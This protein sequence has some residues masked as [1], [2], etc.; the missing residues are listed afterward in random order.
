[1][2]TTK[3]SRQAYYLQT[4]FLVQRKF[5]NKQIIYSPVKLFAHLNIYAPKHQYTSNFFPKTNCS[6]S[7]P[8][9]LALIPGRD[10]K[11]ISGKFQL[12]VQIFSLKLA[13]LIGLIRYDSRRTLGG[14]GNGLA[15]TVSNTMN[16]SHKW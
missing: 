3:F 1:M 16:Y 6:N 4:N 9:F 14:P 2:V 7:S 12:K 13:T 10:Y 11:K 8:Q 5:L 15:T